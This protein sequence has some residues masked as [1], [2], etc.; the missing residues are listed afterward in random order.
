MIGY[1]KEWSQNHVDI[2]FLMTNGNAT[3]DKI[4]TA[5]YKVSQ[6]YGSQFSYSNARMYP[7]T[8]ILPD[9]FSSKYSP[10]KSSEA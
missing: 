10:R 7:F 6:N 2:D 5:L 3:L 9:K 4:S 8:P 1:G